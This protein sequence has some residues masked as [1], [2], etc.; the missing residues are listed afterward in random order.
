MQERDDSMTA[1]YKPPN[2]QATPFS[3]PRTERALPRA[4][5]AMLHGIAQRKRA[6][7]WKRRSSF[8]GASS[9]TTR[10]ESVNI[11]PIT[12]DTRAAPLLCTLHQSCFLCVCVCALFLFL[13]IAWVAQFCR[14]PIMHDCVDSRALRA[15]CVSDGARSLLA[16]VGLSGGS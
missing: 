16:K 10:N 11:S 14:E 2:F 15:Q 7:R 6:R 5:S 4:G 13:T 9:T 8:T 1:G 12:Y 3:L